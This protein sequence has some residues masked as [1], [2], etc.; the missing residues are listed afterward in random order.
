MSDVARQA[1]VSEMTVS[2]VYRRPERVAAST[3]KRV[4]EAAN[5][6]GYVLNDVAGN[7]ASGK[8]KVIVAV[9]PSLSSSYFHATLQGTMDELREQEYQLMLADSGYGSRDEQRVVEAFLRRRPDGVILT[10]ARHTRKTVSM[11]RA[12]E[13]PVVETWEIQGPFIDMAVGYANFD[14]ACKLA[15]L[16]VAKGHREIGYIAHPPSPVQR[17]QQRLDGICQTLD[18]AGL[19]SDRVAYLPEVMG[20][21]GGRIGLTELL[22]RWPRLTAVIAATDVYAAGAMFEC[23]R[24]GLDV[25]GDLAICGFGNAEV[26]RELKPALT[27]IDIRSYEM[28][29]VAAQLLLGRFTGQSPSKGAVDVG[30][31]VIERDSL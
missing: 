22:A 25:P 29:R 26:G 17:H 23:H 5:R 8:S 6:L 20:F 31:E 18:R 2:N 21:P 28:G 27:T 14:A 9:V 15:E 13:V 16:V 24:R 11:L 12:A 19:P 1:G 30:Y 4:L 3:R 10:G 7:L